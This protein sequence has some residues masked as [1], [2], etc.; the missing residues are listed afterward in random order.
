MEEVTFTSSGLIIH[1]FWIPASTS[2]AVSNTTLLYYHG[3]ARNIAVYY[4]QLRYAN[5]TS[6]MGVNVFAIDYPGYGK[7]EGS[8][9]EEGVYESARDGLAWLQTQKGFEPKDIVVLGRSMGS[10]PAVKMAVEVEERGQKF[11]GLI[12]DSGFRS[13]KDAAYAYVTPMF[14]WL[15]RL[16]W[17]VVMDNIGI[18]DQT[19][20]C[21]FVYHSKDDEVV[22]YFHAED[23][24]EKAGSPESC[25]K[26]VNAEDFLHGD[27]TPRHVQEALV[28]WYKALP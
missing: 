27:L 24:Y 19:K 8:T 6:Q 7:S 9:D 10:A 28:T 22:P 5:W 4:R 26:L 23:L 12:I 15:I 20:A 3:S 11:K 2:G 14:G 18:I 16:G 1:A 21:L 13:Y 25:K 17:P